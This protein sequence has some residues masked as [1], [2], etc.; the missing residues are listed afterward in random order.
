MVML[1]AK[2]LG[3]RRYSTAGKVFFFV[4]GEVV[5]FALPSNVSISI[6]HV[7]ENPYSSAPIAL[8][9]FLFSLLDGS[10]GPCDLEPVTRTQS[11]MRSFT[12]LV[13]GAP[14]LSAFV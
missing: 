2:L 3:I 9:L 8:L 5:S 7:A 1:I 11:T 4:Q 14:L 10:P 13:L 12:G 6:R